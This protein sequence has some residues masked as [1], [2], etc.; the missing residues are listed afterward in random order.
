M[1]K[2]LRCQSE[3]LEGYGLKVMNVLAGPAQVSLS[4]STGVLSDPIEKVK[5]AVCPCC[6][7]LSLYVENTDK[8]KG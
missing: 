3:M 4:K 1:R 7:E 8:L 6:G 5:V 2:C